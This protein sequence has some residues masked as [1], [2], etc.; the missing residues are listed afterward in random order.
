M[1]EQDGARWAAVDGYAS[2][3]CDLDLLTPNANQ[4]IYEPICICDQN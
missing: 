4:H 1:Y 3:C 2:A